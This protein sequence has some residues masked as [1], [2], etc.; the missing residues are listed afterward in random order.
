MLFSIR[1]LVCRSTIS[2][3]LSAPSSAPYISPHAPKYV[4]IVRENRKPLLRNHGARRHHLSQQFLR[5]A[6][7]SEPAYDLSFAPPSCAATFFTSNG[8]SSPALHAP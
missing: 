4:R 3:P 8:P 2:P 1:T 5:G 7:S 6:T